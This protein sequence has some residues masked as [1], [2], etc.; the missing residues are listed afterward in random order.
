MLSEVVRRHE[1]SLLAT[2]DLGGRDHRRDDASV[3][4][5]CGGR[6]AM[7]FIAGSHATYLDLIVVFWRAVA[8]LSASD[9]IVDLFQKV[10]DFIV[11]LLL[12]LGADRLGPC[13][14]R[15][16]FRWV[17]LFTGERSRTVLSL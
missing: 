4:V 13:K 2:V 16:L 7:E 1:S 6:R 11:R 12:R 9:Y 14:N 3:G 5:G 17:R 8:H 15:M 10:L